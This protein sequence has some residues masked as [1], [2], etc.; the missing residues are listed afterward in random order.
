M[1]AAAPFDT[2]RTVSGV[3]HEDPANVSRRCG[4]AEV[5]AVGSILG[6]RAWARVVLV[7]SSDVLYSWNGAV[8]LNDS[9]GIVSE[10][11]AGD[12]GESDGHVVGTE[13]ARSVYGQGIVESLSRLLDDRTGPLYRGRG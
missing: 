12:Y 8:R 11:V 1:M 2:G 5:A 10:R 9:Y 6:D 4:G 7:T 3:G 13:C